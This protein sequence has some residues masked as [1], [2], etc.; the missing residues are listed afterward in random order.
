MDGE[1]SGKSYEQM[2]DL[3]VPL[4]LETSIY[5]Y[6]CFVFRLDIH[7]YIQRSLFI[8]KYGPS[9]LNSLFAIVL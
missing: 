7:M 6:M 3:G 8:Q 2:D 9:W 1:N 4:F 5:L